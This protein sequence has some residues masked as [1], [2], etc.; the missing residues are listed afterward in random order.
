MTTGRAITKEDVDA[1]IR[2]LENANNELSPF[3]KIMRMF[4][5]L[6]TERKEN[7]RL[8]NRLL[9]L[10]CM[11]GNI[12]DMLS[13]HHMFRMTYADLYNQVMEIAKRAKQH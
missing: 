3:D 1:T 10:K 11:V 13:A 4:S 8:R 7:E 6:E 12:V 5:E 9:D 2:D